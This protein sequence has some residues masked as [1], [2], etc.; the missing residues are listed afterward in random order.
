LSNFGLRI[1]HPLTLALSRGVER[2]KRER[3]KGK[4]L[5]DSSPYPLPLVERVEG[6]EKGCYSFLIVELNIF[7]FF[8]FWKI[9]KR[10]S[11][12]FNCS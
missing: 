11:A 7:T 5:K 8:L 3:M 9:S 10:N 2:E 6:K 1:Y 4:I 12:T